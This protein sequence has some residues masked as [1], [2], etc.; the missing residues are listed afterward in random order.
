MD[1]CRGPS[2]NTPCPILTGRAG[3][4]PEHENEC[5]NDLDDA[6]AIIAETNRK[7]LAAA[8]RVAFEQASPEEIPLTKRGRLRTTSWIKFMVMQR[9]P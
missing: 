2:E 8:L 9:G 6:K 4:S 7:A 1:V 3:K 5:S